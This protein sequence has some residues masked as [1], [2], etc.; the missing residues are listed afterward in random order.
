MNEANTSASM[1][2]CG[3]NGMKRE[4]SQRCGD[5]IYIKIDLGE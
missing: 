3:S 5:R 1:I 2:V 4:H